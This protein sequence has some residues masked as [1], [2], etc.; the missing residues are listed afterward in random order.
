FTLRKMQ[1]D[2]FNLQRAVMEYKLSCRELVIDT[3]DRHN[4]EGFYF[5]LAEMGM[6]VSVPELYVAQQ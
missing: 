3:F 5:V 1:S 4:W 2:V 6:D